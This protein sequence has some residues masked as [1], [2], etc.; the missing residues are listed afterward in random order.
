MNNIVSLVLANAPSQ[1]HLQGAQSRHTK[2]TLQKSLPCSNASG[3]HPA[4]L[5]NTDFYLTNQDEGRTYMQVVS[6]SLKLK[7]E[8]V[9]SPVI[10]QLQK[11]N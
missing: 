8:T 1:A 10:F 9:I 4:T 7:R 2:P 6:W 3:T 11:Q 5:D